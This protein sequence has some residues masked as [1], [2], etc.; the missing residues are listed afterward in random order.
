[1][2]GVLF[3]AFIIHLMNVFLGRDE[4][5]QSIIPSVLQQEQ[6][7]KRSK[8]SALAS[9]TRTRPLLDFERKARDSTRVSWDRVTDASA[10]IPNR[11]TGRLRDSLGT[12][13]FEGPHHEDMRARTSWWRWGRHIELMLD[14]WT[15]IKKVARICL[16]DQTPGH[17]LTRF[18]STGFEISSTWCDLDVNR[19]LGRGDF[20]NRSN[21]IKCQIRGDWFEG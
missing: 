17:E 11:A 14:Q 5:A 8:E 18:V 9:L 16:Y 20:A 10:I 3:L 12:V 4:T 1:M 6:S 7:R 2:R 19:A 21:Q 15:E 13:Y